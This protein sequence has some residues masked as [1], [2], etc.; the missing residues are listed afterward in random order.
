MPYFAASRTA[1]LSFFSRFG[2]CSVNHYLG[3]WWQKVG[4]RI[5]RIIFHEVYHYVSQQDRSISLTRRLLTLNVIE[6][7]QIIW[8]DRLIVGR[9][10]WLGLIITS[11]RYVS[12][13]LARGYVGRIKYYIV[14]W[15]VV[16]RSS[17]CIT[18]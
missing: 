13:G 4:N 15:L 3:F 5:V 14:L 18:S 10:E 12:T 6:V 16:V 2:L 7:L 1:H 17:P 9:I 8:D 11:M